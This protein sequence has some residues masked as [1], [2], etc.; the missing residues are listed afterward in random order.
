MGPQQIAKYQS[1]YV[2]HIL[3]PINTYAKWFEEYG[4]TILNKEIVRYIWDAEKHKEM[5]DNEKDMY[6]NKIGH[7][8]REW[9]M[10]VYPM[11][12][13]DYHLKLK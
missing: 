5:F 10:M 1:E 8:N 6:L 12:Y 13:V 11:E 7:G 4:F 9:K 2:N 3:R